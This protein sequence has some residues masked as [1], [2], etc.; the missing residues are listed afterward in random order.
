MDEVLHA[1][2][3]FVEYEDECEMVGYQCHLPAD[4]DCKHDMDEDVEESIPIGEY[5]EKCEVVGYKCH[6]P[7][8]YDC[9]TIWMTFLLANMKTSVKL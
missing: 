4:Y 5:E 1:D 8:D 6:F 2:F 3:T 7:D 9:N